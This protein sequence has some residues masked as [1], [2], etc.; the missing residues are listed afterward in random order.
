MINVPITN[1]YTSR[2]IPEQQLGVPCVA[3]LSALLYIN[4][5]ASK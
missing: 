3:L 5:M 1:S 2:T 4:P